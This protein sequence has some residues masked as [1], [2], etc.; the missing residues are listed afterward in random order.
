MIRANQKSP[1]L[2]A[3]GLLVVATSQVIFHFTTVSDFVY[4]LGMGTGFGLILTGL[5]KLRKDRALK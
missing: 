1:I 4:G 2:I 5:W 3:F